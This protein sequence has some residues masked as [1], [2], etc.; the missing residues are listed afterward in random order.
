MM[1]IFLHEAWFGCAS[2]VAHLFCKELLVSVITEQINAP[3]FI[4]AKEA[5][6]LA[7]DADVSVSKKS[8][9]NICCKTFVIL[10]L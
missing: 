9:G 3:R 2:E 8:F 6:K 4:F 5:D 7:N 1:L 10:L